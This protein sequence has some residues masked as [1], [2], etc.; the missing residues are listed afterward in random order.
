[1]MVRQIGH[2]GTHSRLGI[3]NFV[4]TLADIAVACSMSAAQ[5]AAPS[6]KHILVIGEEKGYRHE[7]VSHAMAAIERLGT[8]SGWWDTTLRTDTEALTKKKLEYNAKNLDNFD[9]V[10]FFTGGDLEMDA[11]QKSDYPSFVY[12]HE[13]SYICLHSA[14][15]TFA[16]WPEYGEM[17]GGY[18]YKHPWYKIDAPILF[19]DAD[20]H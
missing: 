20:F 19:E 1:M 12:D 7:S 6:R 9:A 2:L 18:C 5:S 10:V 3:R 4:R 15:I 8:E 14:A 16:D 13:K 17:I 11:Q